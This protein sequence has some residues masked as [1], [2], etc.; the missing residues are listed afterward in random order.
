[1]QYYIPMQTMSLRVCAKRCCSGLATRS[2]SI[3]RHLISPFTPPLHLRKHRQQPFSISSLSPPKSQMSAETDSR[4]TLQ[5]AVRRDRK[6]LLVGAP[7]ILRPIPQERQQPLPSCLAGLEV[8][9]IEYQT[10]TGSS[11]EWVPL[12]IVKKPPRQDQS[13]SPGDPHRSLPVII[14]IHCTGSDKTSQAQHQADY[15]NR[16]YLTAAIDT[17]Y[18]G[19]RVDP[20]LPYQQALVRAWQTGIEHPFLLDVVWDIQK[21]LDVLESRD[22][23]DPNRIGLTGESLGGMIAW[24]AAAADER[25]AVAAPMCGVQNFR[26]AVENGLYHDRVGSIPEIFSTASRDLGKG[27]KVDA[28]V[29]AAVW[30]RVMPGLLTDPPENGYDAPQSLSLIAPRPLLVL[31]GAIDGKTP[32]KGVQQ[33]MSVARKA[34]EAAGVGEERLRLF[35]EPGVGHEFTPNMWRETDLWM[36]KWLKPGSLG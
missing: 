21:L 6:D 20:K 19:A 18:H 15:A 22:D 8:E 12:R 26:Y 5:N 33:A 29:V 32:L 34:Y 36:D 16:G 35:A 2:S 30:R 7:P 9:E 24:L 31:N 28:E 27:G 17:R 13:P 1:M 25:I 23:V 10:E 14:F 4:T 3:I 11:Q